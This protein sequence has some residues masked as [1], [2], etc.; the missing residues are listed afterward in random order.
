MPSWSGL[1][2]FAITWMS[3]VRPP[4]SLSAALT[5]ASASNVS[6]RFSV[7]SVAVI[8]GASLLVTVTVISFVVV[9]PSLSVTL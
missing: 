6:P 4:S 5:S 7:L 2:S 9:F 1:T 3:L 8:V